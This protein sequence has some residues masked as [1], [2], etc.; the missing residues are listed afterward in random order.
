MRATMKSSRMGEL[1]PHRA[2]RR[3]QLSQRAV[4]L[5][6]EVTETA[7]VRRIRLG[8]EKSCCRDWIQPPAVDQSLEN[9]GPGRLDQDDPVKAIRRAGFEKQGD[10]DDY[11]LRAKSGALSA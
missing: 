3:L 5:D 8:I 7:Y 4:I 11:G 1:P 6:H 10:F 2:R 9:R